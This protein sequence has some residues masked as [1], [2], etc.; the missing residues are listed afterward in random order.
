MLTLHC[1][2]NPLRPCSDSP[3][4][5]DRNLGLC[6]VS[7]VP[8]VTP[9]QLSCPYRRNSTAKACSVHTESLRGLSGGRPVC[10]GFSVLHL[11]MSELTEHQAH[12][13]GSRPQGV[14]PLPQPHF[15]RWC[16][17]GWL[18]LNTPPFSLCGVPEVGANAE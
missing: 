1:S 11:R 5:P 16:R 12:G 8:K 15:P 13:C 17:S 9:L 3:H 7:D 18:Q 14:N 10:T 2:S 6:R 4:F